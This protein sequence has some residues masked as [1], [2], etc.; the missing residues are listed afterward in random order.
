MSIDAR[1][2]LPAGGRDAVLQVHGH[3]GGGGGRGRRRRRGLGVDTGRQIGHGERRLHHVLRNGES[4]RDIYDNDML[5][6]H[7]ERLFT[8]CSLWYVDNLIAK[9]VQIRGCTNQMYL[10]SLMPRNIAGK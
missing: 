2:D 5:S 9:Y 4:R 3:G 1:R 8:L 6:V 7:L 10:R